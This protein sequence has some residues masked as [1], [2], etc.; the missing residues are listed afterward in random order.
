MNAVTTPSTNIGAVNR[1]RKRDEMG[2]IYDRVFRSVKR[3]DNDGNIVGDFDRIDI[4][5]RLYTGDADHGYGE[6][7]SIAAPSFRMINP[8][9]GRMLKAVRKFVSLYYPQYAEPDSDKTEVSQYQINSRP[10]EPT[11]AIILKYERKGG[12]GWI[13]VDARPLHPYS[14]N[15]NDPEIGPISLIMGVD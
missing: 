4:S 8:T 14:A 5:I 6:N 13:H 15:I 9:P 10:D 2:S 3:Y 7:H 12:W 11:C 1:A